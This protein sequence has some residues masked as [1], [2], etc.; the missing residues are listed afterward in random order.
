MEHYRRVR[1]ETEFS[2]FFFL[3][4]VAKVVPVL[5][6]TFPS[7]QIHAL[8]IARNA[9]LE[10]DIVLDASVDL[11]ALPVKWVSF[12]H[13]EL[14]N[15]TDIHVPKEHVMQITFFIRLPGS[16]L[17][18]LSTLTRSFESPILKGDP[19][20]KHLRSVCSKR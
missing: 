19:N 3:L 20:C 2:H 9:F 12:F 11:R 14:L 17:E 4:F 5:W 16:A 1:F 8:R 18:I 15:A 13:S 7:V 10:Q 6:Q